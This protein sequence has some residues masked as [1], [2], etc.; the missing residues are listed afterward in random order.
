M[1]SLSC[2]SKAW[3]RWLGDHRQQYKI[4][5]NPETTT[6]WSSRDGTAKKESIWSCNSTALPV[7]LL[8][9]LLYQRIIHCSVAAWETTPHSLLDLGFLFLL[10]Q[11]SEINAM[12]GCCALGIQLGA[13]PEFPPPLSQSFWCIKIWVFIPNHQTVSF[14]SVWQVL[15]INFFPNKS[16][17]GNR[18]VKRKIHLT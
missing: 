11:Q 8:F 5:I 15:F 12:A 3:K 1:S 6:I 9:I 16:L 7:Q 18:K 2:F 4:G 13:A 14:N 10:L 17:Q